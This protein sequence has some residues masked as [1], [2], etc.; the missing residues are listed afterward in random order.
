MVVSGNRGVKYLYLIFTGIPDKTVA[1]SI[2][3]LGKLN[4]DLLVK[5][6]STLLKMS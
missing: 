6:M 5:E 4:P 2:G 1:L 3:K